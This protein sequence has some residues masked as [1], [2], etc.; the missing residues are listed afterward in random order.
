MQN[1]HPSEFCL[2]HNQLEPCPVCE[3]DTQIPPWITRKPQQPPGLI[4]DRELAIA[5]RAALL[6]IV[7]AIERRWNLRKKA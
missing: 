7:D 5:V 3:G 4:T 1:K 6:A 2:E